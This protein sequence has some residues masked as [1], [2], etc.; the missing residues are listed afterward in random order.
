MTINFKELDIL[1]MTPEL[2]VECEKR[3]KSNIG[4]MTSILTV[5]LLITSI[6]YFF[7][8]LF[9]GNSFIL[10]YNQTTDY[11]PVFDFSEYPLAFGFFDMLS[12]PIS[13][14]DDQIRIYGELYKLEPSLKPAEGIKM[15]IKEFKLERCDLKSHFSKYANLFKKMKNLDKYYCIPSGQLNLTLY[16]NYADGLNPNSFLVIK[17]TK[18]FNDSSKSRLFPSV[19]CRN[20]T[21]IE[22]NIYNFYLNI[23]FIDQDIDHKNYENSAQIVARSESFSLSSSVFTGYHIHKKVVN[24][25]TDYGIF[26]S[27]LKEEVFFQDDFIAINTDLSVNTSSIGLF[28]HFIFSLSKKTDNYYRKYPK[29]QCAL[30]KIGGIVEGI[31]FFFSA[32]V[33]FLMKKNYYCDLGNQCYLFSNKTNNLIKYVPVKFKELNKIIEEESNKYCDSKA[34]NSPSGLWMK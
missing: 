9:F 23:L 32:V 4:A 34:Y 10:I 5:L 26:F 25:Q 30:A 7:S 20:K 12:N 11:N 3:K 8:E 1:G 31:L 13:D 24:Y 17:I 2:Y 29:I 27:N 16:G 18:C 14:L 28:S 21:E 15:D 33:K 19:I 22:K 6:G